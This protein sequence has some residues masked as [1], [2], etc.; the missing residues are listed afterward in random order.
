MDEEA[1]LNGNWHFILAGNLLGRLFQT[2]M[3]SPTYT[4]D[5][6]CVRVNR[7]PYSMVPAS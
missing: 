4:Q 5:F 6:Q 2:K 7:V 1:V 3:Q